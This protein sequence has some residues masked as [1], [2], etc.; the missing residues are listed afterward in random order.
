MLCS[1]NTSEEA[2]HTHCLQLWSLWAEH[3]KNPF[4]LIINTSY[5]N[6]IYLLHYMLYTKSSVKK[7]IIIKNNKKGCNFPREKNSEIKLQQWF[8]SAQRSRA[9]IPALGD[10]CANTPSQ[11]HTV[12]EDFPF[13]EQQLLVARSEK[14]QK[15]VQ[16]VSVCYWAGWGQPA[17]RFI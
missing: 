9:A 16:Q 11:L 12:T 2:L 8:I 17:L 4:A 13:P 6:A 3:F 7:K 10:L 1:I 15:A 14:H 5:T